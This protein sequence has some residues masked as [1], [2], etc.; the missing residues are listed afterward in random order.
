MIRA[1]VLLLMLSALGCANGG[2]GDPRR[3]L[4]VPGSV[5]AAPRDAPG[6]LDAGA[7]MD[8]PDLP[9]ECGS[10]ETRACT[11]T[12]ASSGT[13]RCA[14]ERWLG[15][16]P[17][18]EDCNG[19]DDDCDGS[20]DERL[21]PRMCSGSCGGGTE[22]CA[23]GTWSGC[24][25]TSPMPETCNNLDDDCDSRIDEML[26]RAC[27]TACGSGTETC[28]LGSF[29]GCT[30]PAPRT[31]ICNGVNDDCDAATDENI[32]RACSSA[33]GTGTERCTS[34][35]FFGCTAPA[36]PA[37]S[38]NRADDDCDTV[39]DETFQVVAYDPVAMGEL[40]A[41]QAACVNA[42]SGLDV[43]LT[44]SH[45]WCPS[46]GC[47]VSGVG[48]LQ[49]VPGAARVL[50]MGPRAATVIASTYAEVSVGAAIPMNAGNVSYRVALSASN[51]FCRSRGYEGGYGPVEHSDPA[52]YVTCM[53]APF[54]SYRSIPT[55]EFR[56][57]GCDPTVNAE[58][59]ACAAASDDYCRD[60][61]FEGGWGPVEWNDTESAVVCARD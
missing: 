26:T 33:C 22:S 7:P 31:E 35:A 23:G 52:F 47:A 8:A 49:A 32:T 58:P 57:R 12:C 40:T 55:S 28:T 10:G 50:C 51:R 4:D 1:L 30:A 42:S 36:V 16:E 37:E 48:L 38:C 24:T 59:V 17:P 20:T 61:G 18:I 56:T 25:A 21:A 9:A 54:A 60:N 46:R 34:G 3:L 43:C 27:S 13:Q 29:V 5:D 41:A 11:T 14:A 53:S 15:C 39:V 45:R 6:A 19:A 2:D 44:A